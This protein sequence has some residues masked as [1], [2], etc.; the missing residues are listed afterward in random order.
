ML[1]GEGVVTSLRTVHPFK[2][3]FNFVKHNFSNFVQVNIKKNL[4]K[5]GHSAGSREYSVHSHQ[6]IYDSIKFCTEFFIFLLNELTICFE[7]RK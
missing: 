4:R 7:I 5:A 1:G 2:P 6:C 3:A